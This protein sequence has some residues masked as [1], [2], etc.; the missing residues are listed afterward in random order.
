MISERKQP[1]PLYTLLLRGDSCALRVSVCG[2]F[3][4][5]HI[6]TTIRF[7]LG[8]SLEGATEAWWR[9]QLIAKHFSI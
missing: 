4:P 8:T 5:S 9:P 7:Y 2:P 6:P 1:R 3:S